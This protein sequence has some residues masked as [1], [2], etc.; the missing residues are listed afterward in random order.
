MTNQFVTA[1][2]EILGKF[3]PVKCPAREEAALQETAKYLNKKMS[4]VQESGKVI[5]LER[6]AIITALNMAH[7]FLEQDR[8]KGS[9]TSKINQ[10]ITKLQDKLD[11]ALEQSS[12]TELIYF[13]E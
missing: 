7:E 12:Q 5:N 4:E 9:L 13:T 11:Q 3:Y 6:I 10:H 2:I 8:Q 1:T